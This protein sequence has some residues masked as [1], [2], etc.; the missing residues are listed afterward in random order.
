MKIDNIVNYE[1]AKNLPN[2][3]S[4]IAGEG[5]QPKDIKPEQSENG[6]RDAIVRL[7]QASKEVQLA[8][9]II[10]DTPEIRADKVAEIRDRIESGN[11]EIDHEK[12]ASKLVDSN[13]EE[14][15]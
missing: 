10:S 9:K 1:I 12:I 13:L 4:G 8:N 5:Q 15:L 6:S 11:Y 14:I 2:A 7:S 3:T